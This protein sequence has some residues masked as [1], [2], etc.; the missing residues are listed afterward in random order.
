MN[1]L[2][3]GVI[4]M[5]ALFTG[6]ACAYLAILARAERK[7]PRG[8]TNDP[9]K[10][11]QMRQALLKD[12]PKDQPHPQ[13]EDSRQVVVEAVT[14]H[15]AAKPADERDALRRE[16]ELMQR[17]LYERTKALESKIVPLARVRITV[18]QTLAWISGTVAFIAVLLKYAE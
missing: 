6:V 17:A 5:S 14:D 4:L 18:L 8:V 11:E 16:L 15:E 12:I 2:L 1:D 7:G 10:A 3:T 13:T 9:A